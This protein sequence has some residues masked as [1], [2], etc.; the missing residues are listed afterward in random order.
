MS[1]KSILAEIKAKSEWVNSLRVSEER[2]VVARER[3]QAQIN[4]MNREL[5]RFCPVEFTVSGR[6]RTPK[7]RA[8]AERSAASE[9]DWVRRRCLDKM[10]VLGRDIIGMTTR[11]IA[12]QMG[13]SMPT[14]RARVDRGREWIYR[15][16]R[17]T[18]MVEG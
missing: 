15:E 8:K 11:E 10:A 3:L 4:V 2:L 17:L 7:A 18:K 14:V 12:C 13:V 16:E 1:V 5:G 6:P 9:V